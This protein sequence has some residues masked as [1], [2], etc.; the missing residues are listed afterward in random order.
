MGYLWEFSLSSHQPPSTMEK[1]K[2]EGGNTIREGGG[3]GWG[4]CWGSGVFLLTLSS[5]K[6][7]CGPWTRHFPPV[8]QS[9]FTDG[10]RRLDEMT[11]WSFPPHFWELELSRSRALESLQLRQ[12]LMGLISGEG[13]EQ[14]R[15]PVQRHRVW[16]RFKIPIWQMQLYTVSFILPGMRDEVQGFWWNRHS[17]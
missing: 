6:I 1:Y 9:I 10:T 17:G 15:C 8:E 2:Y 16:G 13:D 5:D 4:H 14:L 12:V 7:Q 3:V 11:W